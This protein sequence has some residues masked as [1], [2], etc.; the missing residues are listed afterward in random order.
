MFLF[1]LTLIFSKQYDESFHIEWK[2]GHETTLSSDFLKRNCNSNLSRKERAK[3]QQPLL[4]TKDTLHHIP[5]VNYENVINNDSSVLE[6]LNNL[7]TEGICMIKECGKDEIRR[8]RK[9]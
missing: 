6:W 1:I 9:E 7:Q 2:D 3:N 5:S 8:K 4:W